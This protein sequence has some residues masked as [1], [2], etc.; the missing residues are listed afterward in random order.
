VNLPYVA[1]TVL[2]VALCSAWLM[3]AQ[4]PVSAR[5]WAFAFMLLV[6]LPLAIFALQYGQIALDTGTVGC[7]RALPCTRAETPADFWLTFVMIYAIGVM[8][9]ALASVSTLRLVTMLFGAREEP[10]SHR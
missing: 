10:P 7:K 6:A 2:L 9:A 3:M 5:P 1:S 4:K 8:A